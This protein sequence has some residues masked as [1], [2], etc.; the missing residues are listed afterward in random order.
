MKQTRRGFSTLDVAVASLIAMLSLGMILP[1]AQEAKEAENRKRCVNNL[2]ELGLAAHNF[3]AAYNKLPPGWMGPLMND[4]PAKFEAA[5]NLGVLAFLLP[6]AELNDVYRQ[7][8]ESAGAADYFNNNVVRPAWFTNEK[9]I[10]PASKRVERFLC[11]SA[12]DMFRAADGV[13]VAVH[14]AH[15]AKGFVLPPMYFLPKKDAAF[16]KLGRTNYFG[17]AGM[18]GRGSNMSFP[19]TRAGLAFHEGVF[20]NRSQVS[21]QRIRDGTSHTLLFGE[22]TGGS[23]NWQSEKPAAKEPM[24]YAAA[25][26]GFGALPTAGGLAKHGEPSFWYQFSSAHDG[27]VNF[28]FVDGAVR[29]LRTAKTATTLYPKPQIPEDKPPDRTN[30]YWILQELAGFREGQARPTDPLIVKDPP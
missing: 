5:Q 19:G 16:E 18:Y 22:G 25:W 10:I 23:H 26:M 30:A 9:L 4:Q 7:I 28:C 13:T 20:T 21:M 17:V 3:H 29:Q 6:Y 11:P 14:F 15:D 1:A 27:V 24:Q 2:K 8:Q 12:P